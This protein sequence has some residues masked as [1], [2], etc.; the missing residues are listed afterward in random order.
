MF[1]LGAQRGTTV[2]VE[3]RGSSLDGSYAAWLGAGTRLDAPPAAAPS[4]ADARCAR[5]ADGL[6]AH[7]RAIQG[8]SRATLRL[9]IA[10]DARVGF[11]NLGLIAPSGLSA[12]IP[13]WV[14]AHT[15]IQE[16]A[17]PHDTPDAAQPVTLPVAVNGRITG[18]GRLAYYSFEVAGEPTVA[19]EV[20]RLHGNDFDPQFALYE[21][22]GRYLDPK[23]SKRLLFHE[24]VTL[25][26]MPASRRMTYHF[27]RPGR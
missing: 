22:G 27:T 19:F 21:A 5:S 9:V 11:H 15:V 7:V 23:R 2:D 4:G 3:I 14:G 24:E 1:P 20:V 18:S 25:G 12:T 26:G 16:A 17:A 6:E 13:F 8:G 10:S